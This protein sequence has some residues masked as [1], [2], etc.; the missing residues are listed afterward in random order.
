LKS[1][2]LKPINTQANDTAAA[3]ATV[4]SRVDTC[5]SSG[6]VANMRHHLETRD[7]APRN[8]IIHFGISTTMPLPPSPNNKHKNYKNGSSYSVAS[9]RDQFEEMTSPRTYAMDAKIRE[10]VEG[11]TAEDNDS[12]GRVDQPDRPVMCHSSLEVI[13][14]TVDENGDKDSYLNLYKLRLDRCMVEMKKKTS[15][16]NNKRNNSSKKSKRGRSSSREKDDRGVAR[17][18][19]HH[20]SPMTQKEQHYKLF[21]KSLKM[22]LGKFRWA[23]KKGIQN[24]ENSRISG[25]EDE[26]VQREIANP[27]N[28]I[29]CYTSDAAIQGDTTTD[30]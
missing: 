12:D 8:S 9:I 22:S 17:R 23:K 28:E 4:E 2:K 6:L 19:S 11:Y 13:P 29:S 5:R 25:V 27:P 15:K 26:N 1:I 21:A 30:P 3:A 16:S 10:N 20:P 24:L 18:E 14:R 7:P